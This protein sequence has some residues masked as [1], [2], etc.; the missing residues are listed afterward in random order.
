MRQISLLLITLFLS[1]SLTQAQESRMNDLEKGMSTFNQEKWGDALEYF[2][3]WIEDHTG[4]A[5][6]YVLRGQTQEQLGDNL[7]ANTDFS[8]AINLEPAYAEAFFARGRSRYLLEQYENA[9]QD[10]LNYLE[11]PKG[12]T[13]QIIFRKSPGNSGFSEIFTAQTENPAQAYYHLGLCSMGLEEFESA[14]LYFDMAIESQPSDP[15]YFSE[16]GRALGR[17]GENDLAILAFEWALAL[18]ENNLS[19]KQGLNQVK[20][21]GS[22][23]LLEDLNRTIEENYANSQTFKQRGFYKLNHEDPEGA[24]TDFNSALDLDDSDPETYYYR[25]RAHSTLENF[26]DAEQDF[27]KSISIDPQNLDYFLS[28]GQARYRSKK[29]KEALADFTIVVSLDPESA[30]GYFHKGIT[31]H[32]LGNINQACKELVKADELG[33]IQAMEVM[34][35]ICK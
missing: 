10:F 27:T 23:E 5:K 30:T 24:L 8:I 11:L 14:V 33:M 25:G 9:M 12:E 15:D 31:Y 28:R 16:K 3:L 21:G 13:N 20:N 19:A 1:V 7:K 22:E 17:I 2:N 35:K 4:D 34:E 26:E 18:D 6:A 29:L 32:R